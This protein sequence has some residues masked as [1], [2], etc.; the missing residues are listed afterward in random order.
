MQINHVAVDEPCH[1]LQ[2][3]DKI[4]YM[5]SARWPIYQTG[6]KDINEAVI[7]RSLDTM[8]QQWHRYALC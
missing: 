8:A 7:H 6:V 2:C 3:R 4:R 5:I 1:Q